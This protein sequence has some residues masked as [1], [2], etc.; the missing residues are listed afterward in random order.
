MTMFKVVDVT[1]DVWGHVCAV[2]ADDAVAQVVADI[3]ANPDAYM[4]EA[5]GLTAMAV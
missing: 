5:V 2:D 4:G 1:G 3:E